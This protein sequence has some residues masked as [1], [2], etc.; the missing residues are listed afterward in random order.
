MTPNEPNKKE[1]DSGTSLTLKIISVIIIIVSL[2][3]FA[4]NKIS[5][6]GYI[7]AGTIIYG[8]AE[9]IH[10]LYKINEKLSKDNN[11]AIDDK[12]DNE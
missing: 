10:F 6:I 11:K 4:V 8:I 9:I 2:I 7:I 3:D 12:K 5:A 1:Y